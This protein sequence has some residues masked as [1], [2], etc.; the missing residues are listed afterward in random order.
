MRIGCLQFSPV[1][2]DVDNNLSRA[3]SVL[4]K[5]TDADKLDLI[6]LPELAFTGYNFV[7]RQAIQP[8]L[9]PSLSG[10][11]S[12]WARTAALRHDCH[13][14]VGYP[15]KVDASGIF[16]DGPGFYN[17]LIMVSREGETM[18]K[19]RKTHL[20]TTDENW[21][22]EGSGFGV[23]WV[24]GVGQVAVGICADLNPHPRKL[25]WDAFEFAHHILKC[26]ADLAL[27]SMSWVTGEDA[28]S[29]SRIPHE[30]DMESLSYWIAR[31]E[32]LIRAET[33]HE[34]LVVIANRTG[35]DGEMVFAGT[36]TVLGFQGGEVKLYGLMGRGEKGLLVVDT[37]S[38]PMGKLVYRPE[39]MA[40]RAMSPIEP[41]DQDLPGLIPNPEAAHPMS[42]ISGDEGP[43]ITVTNIPEAENSPNKLSQESPSILT[44]DPKK[45]GVVPEQDEAGS[46]DD[47]SKLI[48]EWQSRLKAEA[49]GSHKHQRALSAESTPAS[50]TAP[51]L[52]APLHR[53]G[54][55]FGLGHHTRH[56][57]L[58]AVMGKVA[59]KARHESP[60]AISTNASSSQPPQPVQKPKKKL[61]QPKLKLQT[62]PEVL[63]KME[64]ELYAS[65]GG[66]KH[67]YAMSAFPGGADGEGYE[68]VGRAYPQ[69]AGPVEGREGWRRMEDKVAVS[70]PHPIQQHSHPYS[71]Q[72]QRQEPQSQPQAPSLQPPKPASRKPKLSIATSNVSHNWKKTSARDILSAVDRP[73]PAWPGL[74]P[75]ATSTPQATR[76]FWADA[77]VP[78]TANTEAFNLASISYTLSEA[79]K[80][81][82]TPNDD[83]AETVLSEPESWYA[84]QTSA[85]P[86]AI[87]ILP[88]GMLGSQ[89]A[90]A[91]QAPPW[92]SSKPAPSS[93]RF[94]S[95]D[96]AL[97]PSRR[98]KRRTRS[99]DSRGL[100]SPVHEK[101]SPSPAVARRDIF[102]SAGST[103]SSRAP[104][105]A[106]HKLRGTPGYA[107]SQSSTEYYAAAM[108]QIDARGARGAGVVG[109]PVDAAAGH[110]ALRDAGAGAAGSGGD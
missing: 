45:L 69:T 86:P 79:A 67:P 2:G 42:P 89:S 5:A 105:P 43:A 48:V 108:A 24:P 100:Y 38:P 28:T 30:P 19:Y 17:S 23:Q 25:E 10:I 4:L 63:L 61:T 87:K 106:A 76:S 53:R 7:S 88:S 97:G 12:L 83:P 101:P 31:L 90:I 35:V 21:A 84:S 80:L 74:A 51:S 54:S 91:T 110:V 29:W 66:V 9:E 55:P 37:E 41:P 47:E 49:A 82:T 85:S 93:S 6:L 104:G 94:R 58:D 34:I 39:D 22:M 3:D 99:R 11:S 65:G 8:F 59:P 78:Q 68:D 103:A 52:K 44:K 102:S 26:D 56:Q 14:A 50:A 81:S 98:E 77:F 71:T 72:Q 46:N 96:A 95:I 109:G 70:Q 60:L 73:A 62:D 36:S 33:E 92:P 27:I 75:A 13:V 40:K 18:M 16:A 15:E 20:F 107:P 1:R 64:D 32:P 57:S